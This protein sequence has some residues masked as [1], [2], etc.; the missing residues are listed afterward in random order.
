M[1]HVYFNGHHL[2][3]K[4]NDTMFVV[5]WNN[6]ASLNEF[7]VENKASK[8]AQQI[9]ILAAISEDMGSIPR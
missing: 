4:F 7:K 8:V 6:V 9:N 3:L 2:T 5:Q 1:E